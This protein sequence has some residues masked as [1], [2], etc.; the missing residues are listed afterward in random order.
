[1]RELV[2]WMYDKKYGDRN[3]AGLAGGEWG[4]YERKK[5]DSILGRLAHLFKSIFKSTP[6]SPYVAN[7]VA[8]R[9]RNST[10]GLSRWIAEE[11]IPCSHDVQDLW[12][13]PRDTK[14]DVERGRGD[15]SSEKQQDKNNKGQQGWVLDPRVVS[16]C[17]I[18]VNDCNESAN[19]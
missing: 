10:D 4:P 15:S 16:P 14:G 12:A 1:M 11:L 6:K 5:F 7:L 17:S 3:I 2:R 8:P 13:K 19:R 9:G 18:N